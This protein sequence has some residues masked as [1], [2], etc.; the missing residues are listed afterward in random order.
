MDKK[1]L[2]NYVRAYVPDT[3]DLAILVSMAKGTDRSMAEFARKCKV[4]GP[5]TFS[6]IVNQLIDKPLSDEL[7]F[8][9][10][11]N[12]A[13]KNEVTLDMLMRA[14][15][16]IPKE[17]I[18]D[19]VP[20]NNNRKIFNT[21]SEKIKIIR[22]DLVQLYLNNGH[23][24]QIYPDLKSLDD[25][26]SSRYGLTIPSDFALHVQG[27]DPLYWNYIVDFTD[28]HDVSIKSA[29]TDLGALIS[30]TMKRYSSLF[31]RD[32]W[33]PETLKNIKNTII[34]TEEKA[35]A[36]FRGLLMNT[37]FNSCIST[38]F[39]DCDEIYVDIEG[40]LGKL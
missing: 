26:P 23:S 37:K 20:V 27:L 17:E 29:K 21:Q 18:S 4:K 13:N 14:N 22:D 5:S 1:V 10:A 15:G 24:V 11:E 12:A 28:L 25:L 31:L 35:H 30:N 40:K 8:S 6:R 33:E 16:K 36:I 2:N 19:G 34:F 7:I 32:A 9:I 38:R 39:A 3:E